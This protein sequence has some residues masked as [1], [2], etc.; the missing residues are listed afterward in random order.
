MFIYVRNIMLIFRSRRSGERKATLRLTGSRRAPRSRARDRRSG[1][2]HLRG[3][4]GSAPS[5]HLA[6][7]AWR[8]ASAR[9]RTGSPGSRSRPMTRRCRTSVS[10]LTKAFTALSATGLNTI[11]NSPQA[12]EK[13]RF[14]SA[15][16]GWLSSAG[17]QDVQNLRPLLQAS[18][19]PSSPRPNAARAARPWCAGR[20]ARDTCR[21]GRSTGP[22]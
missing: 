9:N 17:M 19:R 12:P 10:A 11:A 4:Y 6:P 21:R 2:R 15:C 16:C 7:T 14:Q 1:R 18:A 13:S 20:A 5:V 3:R 8:C 22:W